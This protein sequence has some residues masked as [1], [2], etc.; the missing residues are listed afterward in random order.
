[1]QLLVPIRRRENQFK[2]RKAK[3]GLWLIHLANLRVM[4]QCQST[5][6]RRWEVRTV[7]ADVGVYFPTVGVEL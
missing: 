2:V 1:M 7:W 3:Q 4:Y 6:V 5:L